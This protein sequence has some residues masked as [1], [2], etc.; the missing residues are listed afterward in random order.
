MT[1]EDLVRSLLDNYVYQKAKLLE[2]AGARGTLNKDRLRELVR[3]RI[4][5]MADVVRDWSVRPDILMEAVFSWAKY[6]RHPDGPMPNMLFSS[7]YLAKALSHHLQVPYEVVMEKRS[8]ALFLERMD[9]EHERFRKDLEKAGDTDLS[10]AT[11]Y[12]VESR[13]ALAFSQLDWDAVFYMSQEVL[14][15]MGKDRRVT[16]WMN[17]RGFTYSGIAGLF[18]AR[19]KKSTSS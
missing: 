6:N 7:K 10:T 8:V 1:D 4:E 3:P 5:R 9:F 14:E 18:N 15:C 2:D 17:H 13:Y 19:K 16:T 11:S 12:P